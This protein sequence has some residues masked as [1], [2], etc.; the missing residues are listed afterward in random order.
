LLPSIFAINGEIG[1]NNIAN[2]AWRTVPPDIPEEIFSVID[3][4]SGHGGNDV[5]IGQQIND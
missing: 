1:N 5:K 3:V 2:Q 4:A